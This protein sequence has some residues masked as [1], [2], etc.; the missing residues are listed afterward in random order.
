L[1]QAGEQLLIDSGMLGNVM[2]GQ[3]RQSLFNG[4]ITQAARARSWDVILPFHP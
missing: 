3:G 2:V 4:F 1:L